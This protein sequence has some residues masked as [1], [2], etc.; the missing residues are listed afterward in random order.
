MN[1]QTPQDSQV[2]LEKLVEKEFIEWLIDNLSPDD[3]LFIIGGIGMEIKRIKGKNPPKLFLKNKLLIKA[4]RVKLRD[5]EAFPPFKWIMDIEGD[6]TKE[7][8][9]EMANKLGVSKREKALSLFLQNHYE[10]ALEIYE[11]RNGEDTAT[12]LDEK[13]EAS[14]KEDEKKEIV[15]ES[16]VPAKIEKRLTQ[17]I[18]NLAAER[19]KIQNQLK[20][21]QQELK[22]K[23]SL[24][25]NEINRLNGLLITEKKATEKALADAEIEKERIIKEVNFLKEE[26]DQL[27]LKSNLISSDKQEIGNKKDKLAFLGD[28]KNKGILKNNK[29]DIE[30]FD[31][32]NFLEILDRAEE[33][34][35]VYLL[36]WRFSMEEFDKQTTK[37]ISNKTTPIASFADLRRKMEELSNVN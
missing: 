11:T 7:K 4:T 19:D 3:M 27:K 2:Q 22:D 25:Q 18:S 6:I 20:V 12:L 17:K 33:F 13:I 1:K 35:T 32:D 30:V 36:T 16:K 9:I 23:L 5:T 21:L 26:N 24:K 34:N 8:L 14:E 37:K 29:Y 10:E 15:Q 31:H 28:P